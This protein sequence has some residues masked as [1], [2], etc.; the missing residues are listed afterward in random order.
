[1]TLQERIALW[2]RP[3]AFLGQNPLTLLGGALTTSSAVTLI[4]FWVFDILL[5]GAAI[6]PY[7][8]LIFYLF[9]PALF[10]VG[11]LLMPLGA[12]LRR[13][14][15]VAAGELPTVYPQADFSVPA[16]RHAF[17]WTAGLTILNVILISTASYQ[18]VQYMDS[19]SFCGQTC[20]T[21]MQ[22]EFTAYQNSPHQRVACVQCH[23]GPGAPWFVRSKLSGLRQVFAVMANTYPRPIPS[24][25]HSLR[26]ARD[27]CEQCHWPE[28]FHGDLTD[29]IREFAEDQPNSESVTTLGLH[30]G[31]GGERS[32][33]ATGIHWHVSAANQID[34]IATDDKRQVIP[35]VSYR[36]PDG[37][38]SEFLTTEN[39]PSLGDL[40]KGER[41]V[42][43]CMDCHNRPTH[44]YD[45]PEDA[46][47]RAMAA[48]RISPALPFAHKVSVDV[49]KRSYSSRLAA[50]TELPGA[51]RDYYR[52]NYSAVYNSQG[53]QIEQAAEALLEIYNGNIF[54]AMNVTWG[55]YPNNLG[56]SDFPGCF[57]CHDGNHKAKDGRV[58]TQDCN[59]C[60]N[61]L[62]MEDPDP[63][64]LHD[65]AGGS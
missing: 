42:M 44:A 36:N 4:G 53:A 59:A 45:L 8:G 1:M 3:A 34:Y 47:N 39:P 64:I 25:V 37:S 12:L 17:G 41:R 57:R 48:D 46:V 6:H 29:T 55:T 5:G 56:H 60:H 61:L 51:L 62:A 7:L 30:V 33:V 58:I 22:P 23:I 49:L 38:V 63:K 20:H 14:K 16:V 43:D 15:L 31:G 54:P 26:P 52:K 18:G 13:H 35:W 21:V 32:G 10:V 65:L 50:Q 24:P 27:T 19:V 28:K 40:A 9:F 11:L 2:L